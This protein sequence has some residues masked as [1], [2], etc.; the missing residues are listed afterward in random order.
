MS[1][2]KTKIT[3][4]G[5][6][7]PE[8]VVFVNIIRAGSHNQIPYPHFCSWDGERRKSEGKPFPFKR[9]MNELWQNLA[10]AAEE[11][12]IMRGATSSLITL[13]ELL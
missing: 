2:R 6:P 8:V 13:I 9:V 4:G 7:L 12:R 3:L 10:I 1:S 5:N 11:I